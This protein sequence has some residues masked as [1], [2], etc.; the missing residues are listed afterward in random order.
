MRRKIAIYEIEESDE[1]I[2]L[3]SGS[4]SLVSSENKDTQSHVSFQNVRTW[5]RID[6]IPIYSF[7]TD[8]SGYVVEVLLGQAN[9]ELNQQNKLGDTPLHAAAWKGYSD[10]V[11]MLLNKGPRTDILN[12][13]KKLALD[14]A[15]NAQ[16][17]SL[18]KRKQGSNIIRTAS[19]AEEYLDDEDSD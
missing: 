1:S 18:L 5:T 4:E 15:T 19:N 9:I 14:M 3:E 12:N 17:A 13:E 6:Q 11:E 16:C 2:D 7:I 10:I 8:Y